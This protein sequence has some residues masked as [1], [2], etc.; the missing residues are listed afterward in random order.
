MKS[1]FHIFRDNTFPPYVPAFEEIHPTTYLV[2][3]IDQT[4]LEKE[5]L[6]VIFIDVKD[7]YN[8]VYK[9]LFLIK[10]KQNFWPWR[11]F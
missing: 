11:S 8:T 1:D 5:F 4:F 10:K 9:F 3:N 2:G 6:S 7:A